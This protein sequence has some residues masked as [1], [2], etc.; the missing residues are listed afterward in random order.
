MCASCTPPPLPCKCAEGGKK[1][2]CLNDFQ[3]RKQT[4]QTYPGHDVLSHSDTHTLKK[5]IKQNKNNIKNMLSNQKKA[6]Q[7]CMF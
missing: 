6:H 2:L 4:K 3:Q 7:T 1:Q 5:Y